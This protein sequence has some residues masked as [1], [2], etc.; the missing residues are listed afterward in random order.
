MPSGAGQ[1][2]PHKE[3][4]DRQPENDP[5]QAADCRL[6]R[7]SGMQQKTSGWLAG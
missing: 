3:K 7:F 6:C 1:Q 5:A 2:E 4:I